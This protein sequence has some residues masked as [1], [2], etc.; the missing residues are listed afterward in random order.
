MPINSSNALTLARQLLAYTVEAAN[1]RDMM[2]VIYV[3]QMIEKFIS[4]T[5][6]IHDVMYLRTVGLFLFDS[7]LL[8]PDAHA[9]PA[10]PC[11]AINLA[12][13]LPHSG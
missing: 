13:N 5:A 1:F 3:A 4:F 8:L 6:Q 11:A 9:L 10:R 12:M 7:V 2:D